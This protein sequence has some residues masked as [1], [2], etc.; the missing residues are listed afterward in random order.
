MRQPL[1]CR[2]RHREEIR[3]KGGARSRLRS[4]PYARRCVTSLTSSRVLWPALP[5]LRTRLGRLW[6]GPGPPAQRE[7]TGPGEEEPEKEGR[8]LRPFCKFF[9]SFF[10]LQT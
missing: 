5:G 2:K 10:S 8:K 3:H 6:R 4:R 7:L 1:S 9:P